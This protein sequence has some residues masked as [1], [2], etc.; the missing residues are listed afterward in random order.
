MSDNRIGR[1]DVFYETD[2]QVTIAF[3][4]YDKARYYRRDRKVVDSLCRFVHKHDTP[5]LI[6]PDGWAFHR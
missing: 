6:Y 1:V 4:R 3:I 2:N 5:T